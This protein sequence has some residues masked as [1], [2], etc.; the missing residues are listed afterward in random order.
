MVLNLTPLI[1]IVF[2]LLVFF[3]LTAHFI[4][5]EAIAIDLPEAENS[6]A[7]EDKGYVEVTLTTDG[8]LLVDGLPTPIERLEESLRGALHAPEKRF[9]RFRGDT[10]AQFG[11]GV[12]II[13]AARAAGAESLD[14]L[15][16]KP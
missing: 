6:E 15:T 16:E 9:I 7:S 10:A 13:D 4:E 12:K 1:D 11:L 5:D 2:L 8:Q 3:M 14:I